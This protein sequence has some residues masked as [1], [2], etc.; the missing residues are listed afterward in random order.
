[1]QSNSFFPLIIKIE[2]LNISNPAKIIHFLS[3]TSG[4]L[5]NLE[6]PECQPLIELKSAKSSEP[7][8]KIYFN[9]FL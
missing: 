5:F 7:L 3:D 8:L 6:L 4:S 2:F 9:C 1:M